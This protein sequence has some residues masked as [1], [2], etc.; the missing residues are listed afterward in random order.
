MNMYEYLEL[1]QNK[2]IA[3]QKGF[4]QQVL[5]VFCTLLGILA[6][7]G[8]PA[9]NGSNIVLILWVMQYIF[10]LLGILCVAYVLWRYKQEIILLESKTKTKV[11]SGEGIQKLSDLPFVKTPGHVFWIE[12]TGYVALILGLLVLVLLRV[13]PLVVSLFP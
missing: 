12:N 11:L 6:S 7:F 4:L 8:T 1:L 13:Y 9:D 3:T 10:L 5:F 2:R